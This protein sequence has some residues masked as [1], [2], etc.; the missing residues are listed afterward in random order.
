MLL[1]LQSYFVEMNISSPNVIVTDRDRGLI[2]AAS[3]A[4]F[5]FFFILYTLAR[6]KSAFETQEAWDEFYESW[7][8][9]IYAYT[10]E[11]CDAA[12][13]TMQDNY[14]TEYWKCPHNISTN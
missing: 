10:S 13:S 8:T 1:A 5:F 11:I 2:A 6:C 14:Y 12:W 7:Q 3:V 9:V 4:F